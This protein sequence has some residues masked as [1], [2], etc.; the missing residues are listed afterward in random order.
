MI[1]PMREKIDIQEV[2]ETQNSFG[3]PVRNWVSFAANRWCEVD[4]RSGSESLSAQQTTGRVDFIF[5]MRFVKG[6]T[7]KMR[8]IFDGEEYDIEAV[9]NIEH[10]NRWTELQCMRVLT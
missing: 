7:T 9:I 4:H 5:R 3:E 1:G 2:V 10:R 6:V 8:V